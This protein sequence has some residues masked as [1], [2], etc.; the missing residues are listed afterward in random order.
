MYGQS[1][2]EEKFWGGSLSTKIMSVIKDYDYECPNS[3][4]D[5]LLKTHSIAA[6]VKA[7]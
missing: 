2:L 1:L 7:F 5:N 3:R 4:F 6:T